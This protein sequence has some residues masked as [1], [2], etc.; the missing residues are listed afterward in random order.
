MSISERPAEAEDRAVPGHWEGELI[1]GSKQS[2]IATLVEHHSRYMMLVKV[3]G[4][5]TAHVTAALTKHAKKLP[6]NSINL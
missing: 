6:R 3:P 4:K 1:T 5:E 2:F